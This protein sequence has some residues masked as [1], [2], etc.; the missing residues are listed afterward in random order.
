MA[1]KLA[2]YNPD[3]PLCLCADFNVD[4]MAWVIAQT[5]INTQTKLKE[6][7]FIDEIYLRNSNT[8]ECC[9]EF[10][11]RFPDHNAGV[12]LYGDATGRSRHTDSNITNWKIIESELSRYNIS[13]HVPTRNP[14]ERDRINSVNGMIC[15]PEFSTSLK[16]LSATSFPVL[17][18]VWA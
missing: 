10:K 12:I 2:Q 5:G 14:A 11:Q 9:S 16:R 8:I 18:K 15:R 4:P 3:M 1:F 7:Y 6:I 13:T 17:L